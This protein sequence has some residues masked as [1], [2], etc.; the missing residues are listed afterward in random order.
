MPNSLDPSLR[1]FD[2]LCIPNLFADCLSIPPSLVS[3]SFNEAL[4]EGDIEVNDGHCDSALEN[5][6][7]DGADGIAHAWAVSGRNSDKLTVMEPYL[8]GTA[9]DAIR[10]ALGIPPLLDG[11][12]DKTK[13]AISILE[14]M[15]DLQR[16]NAC[17]G[18]VVEHESEWETESE[19][20]VTHARTAKLLFG[21]AARSQIV[22]SQGTSYERT[23]SP[24][25]LRDMRSP[26]EEW[27]GKDRLDPRVPPDLHASTLPVSER[28]PQQKITK[29]ILRCRTISD[30]SLH[31]TQLINSINTND[32]RAMRPGNADH[33]PSSFLPLAYTSSLSSFTSPARNQPLSARRH[34]QPLMSLQNIPLTGTKRTSVHLYSSSPS[35]K[36]SKG[37]KYLNVYADEDP[38]FASSRRDTTNA[39]GVSSMGAGKL[40][41]ATSESGCMG[42]C[43]QDE[44]DKTHQ[45]QRRA[46]RDRSRVIEEKLRYA[47][48][49]ELRQSHPVNG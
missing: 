27:S 38:L 4:I 13:G 29:G 32:A 33:N 8:R 41:D 35:K 31:G 1:G 6:V 22:N 20:E 12:S 11:N 5:L 18:I 37:K 49:S 21:V 39:S 44:E 48:V 47:L 16:I 24:Q 43:C 30:A 23:P 3:S 34:D 14:R 17:R 42:E 46:L 2:A 26:V 7:G 19:D 9:R 36:Q 10:S 40:T 45:S 28:G 15:R 25:P